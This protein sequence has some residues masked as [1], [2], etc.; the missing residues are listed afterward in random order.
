MNIMEI[1][2]SSKNI[3]GV[4]CIYNKISGKVYV[5]SSI[6]VITRIGNHFWW[7][8][9][10][11]HKNI[12]LQSAYNKY[13]K[14]NFEYI[15]LEETNVDNL[16]TREQY[17]IDLLNC[18]NRE[19]GYNICEIAGKITFTPEVRA[20]ISRAMTGK[21]LS[22][23]RIEKMR[24][25]N[26]GRKQSQEEKDKRALSNTGKKR[27]PETRAKLCKIQTEL[28]GLSKEEEDRLLELYYAGYSQKEISNA[29][30]GKDITVLYKILKRRNL[31]LRINKPKQKG[32]Q[33]S[34][35]KQ[36]EVIKLCKDG[37]N[38]KEIRQLTGL[39]FVTIKNIKIKH[40]IYYHYKQNKKVFGVK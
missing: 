34:K 16:L 2:N 9:N 36:F 7:L 25:I 38:D 13:G 20:K 1:N 26:L 8:L 30:G 12:H 10:N 3:I 6:E 18:C 23:E 14:E 27:S 39:A 28:N 31:P 22:L 37:V 40:G 32:I 35:E 33:I 24:L 15:I 4:Y 21:K 11:K 29:I 17:Y 19:Y 5:G